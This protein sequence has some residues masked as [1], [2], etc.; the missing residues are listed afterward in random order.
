MLFADHPFTWSA[1][2]TGYATRSPNGGGFELRCWE[3]VR[4]GPA[5]DVAGTRITGRLLLPQV[6]AFQQQAP[7]AL[8]FYDGLECYRAHEQNPHAVHRPRG[9]SCEERGGVMYGAPADFPRMSRLSRLAPLFVSP[10]GTGCSRY[11]DVLSLPE[12]LLATW[13]QSQPD[14]S[15][16]L[17]ANFVANEE[18]EALLS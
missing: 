2:N 1:M 18:I 9:Y 7:L 10:H 14:K 15:Q 6:G 16:P 17:V 8:Y 5:W 11:V 12:G 13:Q 4:R 3:L